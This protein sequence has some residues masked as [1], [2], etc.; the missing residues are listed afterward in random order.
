MDP[1]STISLVASIVQFVDFSA[2]IMSGAKEIYESASGL[3]QDDEILQNTVNEMKRFSSRLTPSTNRPQTDDE[4][5]FHGLVTECRTLSNAI[6]ELLQKSTPRDPQS[7]RSVIRSDMKTRLIKVGENTEAGNGMLEVLHKHVKE[8]R[9]GVTVT[10]ISPNALEQLRTLLGQ[11]ESALRIAAQQYIRRSLAFPGMKG[12][13]DAVENAHRDTFRWFFEA[14]ADDGS[15]YRNKRLVLAYFFFWNPGSKLQ[16]SLTG[17]LGSLLHDILQSCPELVP[18][19]FPDQWRQFSQSSSRNQFQE[20]FGQEQIRIA[21]TRLVEHRDL[22]KTHRFCFFIDGLDEYEET[23]QN[24]FKSMIEMLF[25]W[26]TISSDVKLCV[27][28]REYNVFLRAFSAEK[29]LRL[30]D[31]IRVD[32]NRFVCDMIRDVEDEKGKEAL[33]EK[34][35]DRSDGI[36]LWVALVV[37][38]LR[39]R[40]EDESNLSALEQELQIFPQELKELFNHLFASIRQS[41]RTTAYQ[42]FAIL[43]KLNSHNLK[44]PLYACSFLEDYGKN[45]LFATQSHFNNS[46][47]DGMDHATRNIEARKRING[48]CRGL[49]DVLQDKRSKQWYILFTHRSITEFLEETANQTTMTTHL[50]GFVTEDAISQLLLAELRSR[51]L[52]HFPFS[53]LS[54]YVHAVVSIRAEANLDCVPYR[55]LLS[56]EAVLIENNAKPDWD[57]AS[58]KSEVFEMFWG[59]GPSKRVSSKYPFF[60]SACIGDLG[61]VAWKMQKGPTLVDNIMKKCLLLKCLLH[62]VFTDATAPEHIVIFDMM[63]S[64]LKGSVSPT[65]IP[66]HAGDYTMPFWNILARQA[67]AN[68]PNAHLDSQGVRLFGELLAILLKIRQRPPIAVSNSEEG[69]RMIFRRPEGSEAWDCCSTLYHL[70]EKHKIMSFGNLVE[71]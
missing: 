20:L 52:L 71:S 23:F 17:L 6:L 42:I 37:K 10:S 41:S 48:Y 65:A 44:L 67:V 9:Q 19:V 47:L 63:I 15:E 62:R 60:V 35:L 32:M 22:N 4:L 53:L 12:R 43:S 28:S 3:T 56:L 69:L 30:Q 46:Q 49:V 34:I 33:I 2:K 55:C 16:K 24:D 18:T 68:D 21:F 51:N 29:R 8:L 57:I 13:F 64:L 1:L 31:L 45:P 40:L 26:T 38:A 59:F 36:F 70:L 61:Y 5:E 25:N 11:S 7:K 14:S 54:S 66:T 39:D 50:T 27:S 58:S